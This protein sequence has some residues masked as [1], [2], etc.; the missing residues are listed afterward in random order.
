[1]DANLTHTINIDNYKT[2]VPVQHKQV[3]TIHVATEC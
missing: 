3:Q 1:M 2:K